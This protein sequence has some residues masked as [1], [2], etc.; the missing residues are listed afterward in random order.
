[1]VYH[2]L[3]HCGSKIPAVQAL[4]MGDAAYASLYFFTNP[5]KK[6]QMQSITQRMEIIRSRLCDAS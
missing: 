6:K 5:K 1:M 2:K 3:A 4:R